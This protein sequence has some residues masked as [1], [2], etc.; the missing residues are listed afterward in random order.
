MVWPSSGFPFL[1]GDRHGFGDAPKK[2]ICEL[3]F[4]WGGGTKR[5]GFF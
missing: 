3:G 2:K 5:E 4:F 1:E